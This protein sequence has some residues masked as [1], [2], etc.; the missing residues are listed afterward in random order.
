[1]I[2]NI[3]V[4]QDLKEYLSKERHAELVSELQNLKTIRRKEIAQDLE[5]LELLLF[6]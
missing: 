5:K 3:M 4:N 1:M 2:V 6:F